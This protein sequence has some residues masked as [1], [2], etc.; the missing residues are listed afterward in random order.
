MTIVISRLD[1]MI[2]D[3]LGERQQAIER[4]RQVKKMDKSGDSRDL[5]DAYLKDPYRG[6][7]SEND[8]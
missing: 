1:R 8:D 6:R 5:A 2:H 7:G 3:L 4:Y